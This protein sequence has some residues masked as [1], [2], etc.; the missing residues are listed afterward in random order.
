MST[1][2]SAPRTL[3]TPPIPWLW[4]GG[5]A[6]VT[7]LIFALFGAS[8]LRLQ[9]LWELDPSYSHGYLV[10]LISLILAYRSYRRVGPPVR[11]ELMLG[12]VTIAF[13]ICW[14]LGATTVRWPALSYL[15]LLAVLRG[16]LVCL[17]GRI[18][19]SAFTFPLLFLFFMFPLPAIWTSYASL[20]LQEVVAR[21][22]ETVIGMFVVCHRVGHSIRIAGVD[23]SLVVAEECSGLGQIVAFL[24]FAALLG[25][26]FRRPLW[27]RIVLMV[28]AIP[29]A[30]AANTLRVVLMNFGAYWFGTKWMAGILHDAP[31]LFSIPVGIVLFL[32]FDR[33]LAGFSEAQKAEPSGA[34]RGTENMEQ[35]TEA[36]SAAC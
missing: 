19:A 34:E 16:L 10:P 22:S 26:L 7:G 11:G 25:E 32:V 24:A 18:W 21:I 13:G 31:A 17:G 3:P 12:L 14:Q 8:F 2:L 1:A 33:L 20:W 9:V 23:Q 28:T 29:L 27:Y 15:G 35:Q 4:W 30:I 5:V 36:D 6:A